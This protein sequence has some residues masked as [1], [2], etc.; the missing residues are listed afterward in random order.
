MSEPIVSAVDLQAF[1]AALLSAVG[2]YSDDARITAEV[3]VTFDLRG[4]E[5]HGVAQLEPY[6]VRPLQQ[7]LINAAP[8]ATVVREKTTS[9]VIDA[10]NGL[11]QPVT[12]RAMDRSV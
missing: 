1:A 6:Y 11:G 10:D 5:S 3:L 8:S 2:S 9:I 4:H 7:G 12:K